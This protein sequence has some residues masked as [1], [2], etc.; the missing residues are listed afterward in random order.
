MRAQPFE[1]VAASPPSHRPD[2]P[3][4]L[5]EPAL[6][7]GGNKLRQTSTGVDKVA[8]PGA[9]LRRSEDRLAAR[10]GSDEAERMPVP[11]TGMLGSTFAAGAGHGLM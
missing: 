11:G 7:A 5:N 9:W 6:A 8:E 3:R 10:D 2:Y 1:R 4:P